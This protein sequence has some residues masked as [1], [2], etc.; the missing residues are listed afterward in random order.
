V[1]TKP[2]SARSG[3]SLPSTDGDSRGTSHA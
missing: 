2:R 1:V 3:K